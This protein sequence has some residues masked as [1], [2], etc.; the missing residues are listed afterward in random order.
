MIIASRQVFKK[1]VC[2]FTVLV[3]TADK[4]QL[5][6]STVFWP[7]KNCVWR[8]T[9]KEKPCP[10]VATGR[11]YKWEVQMVIWIIPALPK[12]FNFN[13]YSFFY[14]SLYVRV[15]VCIY[16][17]LTH[18]YVAVI[19][20]LTVCGTVHFQRPSN[21]RTRRETQPSFSLAPQNSNLQETR[22][23]ASAS[24]WPCQRQNFDHIYG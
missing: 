13:V 20:L 3:S 16:F 1:Q 15:H 4:S 24:F 8:S 21:P 18:C 2:L 11:N 12:R 7:E 10:T 9:R 17:S 5:I 14:K 6:K 19:P 22:R 23:K